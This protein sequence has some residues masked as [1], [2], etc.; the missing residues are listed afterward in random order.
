MLVVKNSH[1]KEIFST[2]S[3]YIPARAFNL[4]SALLSCTTLRGN[5]GSVRLVS[6]S[7]YAMNILCAHESGLNRAPRRIRPVRA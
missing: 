7:R 5:A 1:T 6:C 3:L 2:D 4:K